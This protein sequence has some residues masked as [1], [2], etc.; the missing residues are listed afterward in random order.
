MSFAGILA[1]LTTAPAER[2]GETGKRGRI[3]SGA[4]QCGSVAGPDQHSIRVFLKQVALRLDKSVP[5][6]AYLRR[7]LSDYNRFQTVRPAG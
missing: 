2:F 7:E 6:R 5:A 3:A 4:V 1:S